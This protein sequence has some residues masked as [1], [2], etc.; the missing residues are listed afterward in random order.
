M[1][2][3]KAVIGHLQKVRIDADGDRV[4]K[5]RNIGDNTTENELALPPG[6]DSAPIKGMYLVA[7]DTY[8]KGYAK[9]IGMLPDEKYTVAQP[10]ETRIYS[11]DTDGNVKA[12]VY[13]KGDGSIAVTGESMSLLGSGDNL[14]RYSKLEAAFNEL[15]DKFN[16]LV[17]QYNSHV[18]QY[19]DTGG[20]PTVFTQTIAA[21]QQG[22]ES[23]ADITP[24][25]IEEITTLA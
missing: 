13:L 3:T 12:V 7:I 21:P 16:N 9:V 20:S 2:D 25:K 15:N 23:D 19:T 14:V 6:I 1:S 22:Q 4:L 17:N 24:A 8:D 18:H 11:I 10:G 5:Y